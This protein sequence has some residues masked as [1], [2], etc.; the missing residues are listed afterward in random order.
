[1]RVCICMFVF[2][3]LLVCLCVCVYVCVCVCVC[4]CVRVC[5]RVGCCCLVWGIVFMLR[6][7]EASI[8]QSAELQ[9]A[10]EVRSKKV[11]PISD[12]GLTIGSPPEASS[13]ACMAFVCNAPL[14]VHDTRAVTAV[15]FCFCFSFSVG[16][17][18]LL[19]RVCVLCR[20]HSPRCQ[21]PKMQAETRKRC[22]ESCH[23]PLNRSMWKQ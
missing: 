8:L 19:C 17:W 13:K 5:V 3:C 4:A 15:G 22:R 21:R 11:I 9:Y 16:S 12:T 23:I 20:P 6:T 18:H 10:I 2:V 1:M 14:Q 7:T